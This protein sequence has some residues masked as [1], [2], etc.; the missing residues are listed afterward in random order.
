M[1]L[2]GTIFG[3]A[4]IPCL[5]RLPASALVVALRALGVVLFAADT[6]PRAD[7]S[8]LPDGAGGLTEAS[9]KLW[10][11]RVALIIRFFTDE[12][13]AYGLYRLSPPEL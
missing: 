9:V 6:R 2:G 8:A 1:G 7:A 11:K 4:S 10:V 12:A 13:V 5:E 3:F